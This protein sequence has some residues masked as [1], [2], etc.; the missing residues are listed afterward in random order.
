MIKML[1]FNTLSSLYEVL[2]RLYRRRVNKI[3]VVI[4]E[5]TNS[6]LNIYSDMDP[7]KLMSVIKERW[8]HRSVPHII[9]IVDNMKTAARIHTGNV[10][11]HANEHLKAIS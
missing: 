6:I 5:K 11:R 9:L 1:G 2:G 3:I 10:R 8:G 4:Q 7:N